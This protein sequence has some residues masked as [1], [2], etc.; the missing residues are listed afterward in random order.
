MV[1]LALLLLLLFGWL[2]CSLWLGKNGIYDYMRVKADVTAKQKNNAKLKARN[3]QLFAEI[4]D[5]NG[6]SD[7]IEERARS[8]LGMIKPSESFYRLVPDQRGSGQQGVQE[9]Q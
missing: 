5:L 9:S 4:D 7:S 8:E 2:Q 1:K 3:D 6:G